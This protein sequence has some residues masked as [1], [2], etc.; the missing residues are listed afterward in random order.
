MYFRRYKEMIKN[1]LIGTVLVLMMA[2]S[3]G[4]TEVRV[5]PAS[6]LVAAGDPFHV[7]VTVEDV[8]GMKGYAATLNF[9]PGAMQ[10]KGIIQGDILM[11]GGTPMPIFSWDNV[12]GTATFASTLGF[13]DPWTTVSGS[14]IL[15]T[16]EFSTNNTE[17][18]Y[19]LILTGVELRDA[20]NTLMPTDVVDGTVIKDN[21]PPTVEITSPADDHWFDSENVVIT[22]HPWDNTD[23]LLNYSIYVDDEEVDNGTA[24][25]CSNKEV[26]LGELPE[27]DHVIRVNVTD[28][29][30][31]NG[32]A[33]ITVHVDRTPPTVEII[34]PENCTWFDSE[35]VNI[36]FHPWDNKDE[37]LNYSIYIDGVLN[38]TGVAQNCS[39]KEVSLGILTEC[40]HVINV[41]VE[42]NAGKTN[43][44]EIT[45]YV[46]LTPPTVEIISP[47]S[48]NYSSTCVGLNF[49]AEDPGVCPS[50]IDWIGYSLDGG[51]NVTITGNATIG[52]LGAGSHNIVVYVNDT[53]GKEGNSSTVS[54]TLRPGDIDDNCH[55]YLSDLMELADAFNSHTGDPNWNQCADMDCNGHIYLSDL[56]ILADN[57]NVHY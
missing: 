56:M 44:T 48:G 30:G 14:G 6:Q 2:A 50:G 37:L 16:I 26:D 42:D 9:N 53:V 39:N 22:F 51:D 49:T 36:T 46:D 25:N 29:S 45:I 4:A 8:E 19:D 20:N 28:D 27:C 31:L 35:P 11:A 23:E 38:K 41:T 10:V 5:D 7:N 24:A 1:T 52:G 47:E 54:F 21:T 43:S 15:A 33:S 13:F 17:G 34:S 32:S 55:V 3:A 40:D 12:T 57:F 18:T